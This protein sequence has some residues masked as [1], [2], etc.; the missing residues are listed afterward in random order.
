MRFEQRSA[1]DPHVIHA[2]LEPSSAATGVAVAQGADTLAP[3]LTSLILPDVDVTSGSRTVTFVA[4]ARDDG[5]IAHVHVTYDPSTPGANGPESTLVFWN[6]I[7]SFADGNSSVSRTFTAGTPAGTY[8]VTSVRV[9]DASGNVS[10]YG[11]AELAQKGIDTSFTITSNAVPDTTAPILTSLVLPDADVTSGGQSVTFSAG[12]SDAGGIA[13][14]QVTYDPATPG[15][16]GPES[17]L[18]FW[19]TIDSFADGV[20]SLSRTFGADTPAGTYTVSS[21]R[22][23]DMSGNMS[24]YSTADLAALGID[25]NFTIRGTAVADTIAPSLTGLILPDVDVSRGPATA[26]FSAS[27][28]DASGIVQVLVNYTPST[29]ALDGPQSAFTFWNT[30]DSFADGASTLSRTFGTDTPGG[31]YTVTNVRVLDAAGNVTHYDTAQLAAAG[32]DTQ[33]AVITAPSPTA[34]IAAP[35]SLREGSDAFGAIGVTVSGE[36]SVS[37]TLSM[38]LDAANSSAIQG[39]D[40]RIENHEQAFA[41]AFGTSGEFHLALPAFSILND[42]LAEGQESIRIGVRFTGLTFADGSDTS[43]VTIA[44]IDDDIVGTQQEDLLVGTALADEL[45]GLAGDDILTGGLGSD[46]LLGGSGADMF[47][48]SAAGL[49]G[50]RMG[51]WESAD[52]I[53]V[54]DASLGNFIASFNGQRLIFTGG[55]LD[56]ATVPHGRLLVEA[57]SEGG[58]QLRFGRDVRNDFNGDG[59]SDLLWIHSTGAFAGWLGQASGIFIHSG[60][61]A[62]PVDLSWTIV[63]TG[64]FNGDGRDDLLWRHTSG[65]LAEWLGQYDAS[66]A[67]NGAAATLLDP[68]WS[69]AGSGD[70]NGD[71]RSDIAWS[72]PSGAFASWLGQADGSFSHSGKAANPVDSSWRIV[73]TGDFN[74]DGRQDI[75]WRHSTGALAEWIGRDDGA[76]ANNGAAAMGLDPA[77]VLLG[78]GDFNGDA[79]ADI[80]LRDAVGQLGQWLGQ[81]DGAFV[82]NPAL[83][84]RVDP[85]WHVAA[86]GDYDGDGR[87]DLV[88]RH[89][90]GALAEWIAQLDGSFVNSGAASTVIDSSWVIQSPDVFLL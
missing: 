78:A 40:L 20:S 83:F 43:F 70:F 4:G 25:S 15:L 2:D 38:W 11:T 77:W 81:A 5:G 67:N 51:E 21:V 59:R 47:R 42:R 12:A 88:W 35:S 27:A 69:V 74:G 52:R 22:V 57:A 50:D 53:V 48:D 66:F 56:F 28:Q 76:F 54:S 3:V 8:T 18:Q 46:L 26:T 65:A 62:N 14:V 79:R 36:G 44:L 61:A 73:G 86:I 30:I 72:H 31:V 17:S 39:T 33:F 16:N 75:L 37:G 34:V 63:A 64:D 1:D 71:G 68:D 80:L 90:S 41:I 19:N 58:V 87:D 13:Y 84:A 10:I 32:F 45:A 85:T 9:T 82:A 60:R 89:P 49:D 24:I 7:D 29:P 6:T 23:Q 55:A